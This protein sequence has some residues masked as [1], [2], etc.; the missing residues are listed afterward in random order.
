[1]LDCLPFSKINMEQMAAEFRNK[2]AQTIKDRKPQ[3][4]S[5]VQVN[6]SFN[7]AE[8]AVLARGSKQKGV[9]PARLIKD[10]TLEALGKSPS[11]IRSKLGTLTASIQETSHLLRILYRDSNGWEKLQLKELRPLLR[12]LL[13]LERKAGQILDAF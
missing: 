9:P 10:L 2:V 13:Q 7:K 5:R 1:M 4:K 11:D 12:R 6:A 3:K 8:Y